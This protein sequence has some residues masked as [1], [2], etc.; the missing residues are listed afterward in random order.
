MG[1][2][3]IEINES[4]FKKI[5]EECEKKGPLSNQS[6]LYKMVEDKYNA[7]KGIP[8]PISAMVVKLRIEDWGIDIKTKPGKKGKQ[9]V[10]VN[11]DLLIKS[12]QFVEKDGP[13][14]GGLI[15]LWT[16][17]T[18]VYNSKSEVKISAATIMNRANEWNIEYKTQKNTK[19]RGK[20]SITVERDVLEAAIKKVENGSSLSSLADF[21]EAL[22]KE[23]N[24][25]VSVSSSSVGSFA[26]LKSRMEEWEIPSLTVAN[27]SRV[28]KTKQPVGLVGE[29]LVSE[30]QL[31][32]NYKNEPKVSVGHSSN[33]TLS[34][35]RKE[36]KLGISD[37]EREAL[38]FAASFGKRGRIVYAPA[39]N[40][41]VKFKDDS[42]SGIKNWFEQLVAHGHGEG[43]QYAPSAIRYF[44]RHFYDM[45]SQ[46]YKNIVNQI[47]ELV[48]EVN[49]NVITEAELQEA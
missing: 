5:I 3:I 22:T 9:E 37:I 11:K 17:T 39:G 24:N 10:F 8:E 44:L 30:T 33:E 45:G 23:Y 6:A 42:P 15:E 16:K 46:E 36:I 40:C 4:L 14:S 34:L 29:E 21:W 18:E 43:I 41:P 49:S 20:P 25:N 19:G 2:R 47:A 27:H 48:A 12:I 31:N 32:R 1:R 38:L 13:L 28:R 35:G 7:S 26:T